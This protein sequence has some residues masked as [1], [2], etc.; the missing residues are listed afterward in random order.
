MGNKLGISADGRH[1]TRGGKRIFLLGDTAWLM[2]HRLTREEVIQYFD[3]R[4]EKGFNS[5][6]ITLIHIGKDNAYGKEA[7]EGALF[8]APRGDEPD[9]FWSHVDFI[10]SEAAKRGIYCGLLPAWGS[11]YAMNGT[12]NIH[13]GPEYARFL[14]KRYAT[15]F[16]YWVLGGDVRGINAELWDAMGE[17]F[18]KEGNGQ[19]ITYHPFGRTRSAAW[20]HDRDWLHF[21]MYQSGHRRYDQAIMEKSPDNEVSAHW[22]GEDNW[23]YAEAD[24][25][26]SRK[27]PTLDGEPSYEDIPQGLHDGTQPYWTAKDARRFAWWSAL[28]GAAGHI[29]GQNSVMQMLKPCQKPAFHAKKTWQEGLAAPAS[30]QMRYLKELM[31]ALPP[32]RAAQ[33]WVVDNG[34]EHHRVSA[35]GGEGFAVFYSFLGD[36][37]CVKNAPWRSAVWL[38]PETGER[39]LP[40]TPARGEII[41]VTPPEIG[42]DWVLLLKA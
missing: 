2:A 34:E 1:I 26:L 31:E 25:A 24:I 38:N 14:A 42:H 23:R 6:L 30:A 21:N 9:G 10:V 13:N 40:F 28:A 35:Y 8:E 5:V 32:G 17:V 12:L 7:F 3:D 4:R 29:Y 37:F 19:L 20:F 33:E 15:P 41:R 36:L 27:K 39:L 22:F 16:V 11:N 18:L